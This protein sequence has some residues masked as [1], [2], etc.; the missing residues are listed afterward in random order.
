FPL[1]PSTSPSPEKNPQPSFKTFRPSLTSN[2]KHGSFQRD[3]DDGLYPLVWDSF[4]DF[5]AWIRV[6]QS[7][8]SIELSHKERIPNKNIREHEW[9][10]RHIWVC[11]RQG[12][13]GQK[14]YEAKFPERGRKIPNKRTKCPCRLVVKTYPAISAVRGRYEGEHAHPIGAGN[15]KYTRIPEHAKKM[16][17]K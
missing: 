7:E 10:D 4:T 11:A 5:Q 6:E 3:A 1:P 2:A 12:S 17:E 16:I 14:K 13:S 15:L 8:K 9:T